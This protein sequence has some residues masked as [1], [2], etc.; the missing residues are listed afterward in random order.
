MYTRRVK[1][2]R[3][4]AMRYLLDAKVKVLLNGTT[5]GER[6]TQEVS[7][8]LVEK[9]FNDRF[10]NMHKITLLAIAVYYQR[11]YGPLGF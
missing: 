4:T 9:I 2:L 11:L 1:W 7:K 3:F 6:A 5:Y 8:R 10:S